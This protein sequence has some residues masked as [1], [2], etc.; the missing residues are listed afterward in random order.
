MHQKD[1]SLVVTI[2]KFAGTDST[3]TTQEFLA[4]VD[5]TAHLGNWTDQDRVE[6]TLL[7]L[8]GNSRLFY[9]GCAELHKDNLSSPKLKG[10][11]KNRFK[12]RHTGQFH[13]CRLQTAKQLRHEYPLQFADRCRNLAQKIIRKSDNPDEQLAHQQNA[14]RMMPAAF[15]AGLAGDTGKLVRIFNPRTL[16]DALNVATAVQEALRQERRNELLR[17]YRQNCTFYDETS[18]QVAREI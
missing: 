6:F 16:D 11:L 8:A 9:L 17:E 7:K 10:E 15:V 2:P 14:D 1:L 3:I 13:F 4:C 5:S 12:D 18:E